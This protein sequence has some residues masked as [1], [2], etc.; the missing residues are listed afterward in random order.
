[1]IWKIEFISS[2]LMIYDRVYRHVEWCAW[3]FQTCV[4]F[5]HVSFKGHSLSVHIWAPKHLILLSTTFYFVMS[6]CVTT[7]YFVMSICVHDDDKTTLRLTIIN[8]FEVQKTLHSADDNCVS[9]TTIEYL[10][11]L[12]DK[13]V[14]CFVLSF[15]SQSAHL[16]HMKIPNPY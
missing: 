5:Q 3:A 6:I 15:I 8:N 10:C 4:H 11:P 12:T 1:M 14:S 13:I 2:G 7:F 16:M 9:N